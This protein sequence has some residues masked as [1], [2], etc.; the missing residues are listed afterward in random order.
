M[1]LISLG[2]AP[3]A[4]GEWT[5]SPRPARL[6]SMVWVWLLMSCRL[7]SLEEEGPPSCDTLP[8][9]RLSDATATG[10]DLAFIQRCL[11]ERLV[12]QTPREIERALMIYANRGDWISPPIRHR[13]VEVAEVYPDRDVRLRAID[14]LHSLEDR[15]AL[16]RVYSTFQAK[17]GVRGDAQ[18]ARYCQKKSDRDEVCYVKSLIESLKK[19]EPKTP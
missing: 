9:H 18:V 3:G 7:Y 10:D 14:T 15:E 16:E 2:E 4:S 17:A 11:E 6:M 1:V 19:D 13:I 5:A 12:A 8:E